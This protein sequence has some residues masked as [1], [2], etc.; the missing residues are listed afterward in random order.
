MKSENRWSLILG[1]LLCSIFIFPWS[2]FG[3][4]AR[5]ANSTANTTNDPI[6][7]THTAGAG[8][9]VG[10]VGISI[11]D[12]ANDSVVG[13]TWAG[14]NMTLL[15]KQVLVESYFVPHAQSQKRCSKS[16]PVF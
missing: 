6:S 8:A 12:G 11:N 13:V 7:W 9:T 14:Q 10:V 16:S 1:S 4:I 2:V 15:S 3:A 5:D